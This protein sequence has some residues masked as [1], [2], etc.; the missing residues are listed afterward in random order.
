MNRVV[1]KNWQLIISYFFVIMIPK[2][3]RRPIIH[4]DHTFCHT[5]LLNY[6]FTVRF[7]FIYTKLFLTL[8][9][10]YSKFRCTNLTWY[11]TRLCDSLPIVVTAY[12][13]K[14]RFRPILF[15]CIPISFP[16]R[17]FMYV[18]LS[19]IVY[20]FICSFLCVCSS[21]VVL[22]RT[23]LDELFQS[24]SFPLSGIILLTYFQTVFRA[25][26]FWSL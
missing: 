18:Y 24:G 7:I 9:F 25:L 1:P 10:P 13:S 5:F 3:P 21:H 20:I 11:S 14:E 23:S 4:A 6:F 19:R 17:S 12:L 22:I 26:P 15:P 2:I 16:K 8:C